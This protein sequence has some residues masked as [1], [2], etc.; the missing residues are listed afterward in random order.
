MPSRLLPVLLAAFSLPA[1][2]QS[3]PALWTNYADNWRLGSLRHMVDIDNDSLLLR[4]DDGLYT[5][6]VRYTALAERVTGTGR[7]GAGWRIGQEL[8]TAS[9]AEW[10]PAE[11]P[12]GDHPYAGWLYA[13]VVSRME[14]ADGSALAAGLDVGC[15]GP[16]A[17]GR[18]TQTNLHRLLRQTLPQGWATQLRN[19]AGVLA[20]VDW[21][22][23]R[24]RLGAHADAAP[25]LR[26]RLGNIHTDASAGFLLRAGNLGGAPGAVHGFLRMEGRA[27][28][29]NA[30]LSGGYFSGDQPRAVKAKRVT[31]EAELGVRWQGEEFS[32]SAAIVHRANEMRVEPAGGGAQNFARIQI[33]WQPR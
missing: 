4:R 29:W 2:A 16:C 21:T 33:G 1:A 26:A 5:S 28:G 11:I 12:A 17:A 30:S 22:P 18:V 3:L 9:E 19:E 7:A 15:F 6:G 20:W 8:Y 10:T 27:V 14:L 13:G 25:V 31:G 32:A 23:V 24:W